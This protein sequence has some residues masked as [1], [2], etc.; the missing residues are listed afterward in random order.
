MLINAKTLG[1]VVGGAAVIA[2]G[3]L[4]ISTDSGVAGQGVTL[5]KNG[6]AVSS[7]FPFSTPPPATVRAGG[8]DSGLTTTT[9]PGG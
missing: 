1:L 8:Y 9:N 5:A 4:A 7:E 3:A 6:V 2:A